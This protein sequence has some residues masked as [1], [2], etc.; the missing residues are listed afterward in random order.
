MEEGRLGPSCRPSSP[1]WEWTLAG[2][3]SSPIASPP[4]RRAGVVSLV[5]CAVALAHFVTPAGL[6]GWHW[7]HILLQKLF[8]LPISMC[9]R[10]YLLSEHAHSGVEMRVLIFL[11]FE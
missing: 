8:H 10:E 4:L 6:H 5:V 9:G 7:I 11:P 2:M 3:T 1:R